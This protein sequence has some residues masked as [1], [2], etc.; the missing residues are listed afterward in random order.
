VYFVGF[1]TRASDTLGYYTNIPSAWL[2]QRGEWQ[3]SKG[4]IQH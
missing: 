4:T 1:T 2:L 3:R